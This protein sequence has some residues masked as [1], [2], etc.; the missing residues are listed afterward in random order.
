MCF[1]MKGVSGF[2]ENPL[3][4]RLSYL[5]LAVDGCHSLKAVYMSF[6]V[7]W[8]KMYISFFFGFSRKK[9]SY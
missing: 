1:A 9:P 4:A 3:L 7:T 2:G 8:E 6:R 5:R